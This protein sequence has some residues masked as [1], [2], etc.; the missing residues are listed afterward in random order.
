M[1]YRV[2][3][4]IPISNKNSVIAGGVGEG[5][6][7]PRPAKNPDPTKPTSSLVECKRREVVKAPNLILHLENVGEVLP[8][9]Y[10]ARGSIYTILKRIPPVLNSI[11]TLPINRNLVKH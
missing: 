10:W 9:G 6:G 3:G 4:L 5:H 11:P 7:D 8:R 1:N 2:V